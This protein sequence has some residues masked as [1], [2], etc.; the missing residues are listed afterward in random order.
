MP[1]T[2][3]RNHTLTTIEG[4]VSL[5]DMFGVRDKLL[6]IHNM[7]QGCRYCTLWAD[8]FNGFLPH[9][10]SIMSVVLVSK[11]P[12][13]V[14]RNFA[15]SR[16]WRFRLAS[17]GG[18]EYLQDQALSD[19]YYNMPGAVAYERKSDVIFRKNSS[20]FGSGDLYC[21]MWG[22]LALAGLGKEEWTPQY[23]YWRRPKELDDG[24]G[25]IRE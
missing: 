6:L 22:L 5:L 12:P 10:E 25:D 17:L 11:D 13:E 8:G 23:N 2:E 19:D 3:D 4:E 18:G 7:G 24:G 1:T 16:G 14:Q 15:N 21:P 9:L 20:T